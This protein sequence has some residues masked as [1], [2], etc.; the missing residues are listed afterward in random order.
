[1]TKMYKMMMNMMNGES[2]KMKHYMMKNSTNESEHKS[3]HQ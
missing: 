3:Y 2:S 1:M